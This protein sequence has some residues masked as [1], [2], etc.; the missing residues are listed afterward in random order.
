MS[1]HARNTFYILLGGAFVL[2]LSLGI[3]HG[4]GL[5]LLPMSS[6]YG[7]GRH[8]FAFAM[9]LQNLLWG[10]VQP[11][12]GAIAD[13]YG[14]YRVV[15]AGGL[16]YALGLLL[17]GLSSTPLMLNL[18]AGLLI[19]LG[20]SATS[21]TVILG[22]VGRAVAPE[23]RS[24]A[25]GVASAAGSFGQFAMLPGTLMLIKN[26]QWSHA[27]FVLAG[28]A[29][30]I[31]PLAF[32]LR[33][34]AQAS[35]SN[36]RLAPALGMSA[37]LAIASRHRDFWLLAIGFFVCG[38]Q[39]VFIGIHLPSY[40]M[41]LKFSATVG[42]IVLALVGLFNVFG[43]YIAGWLGGHYDK[44]KLLMALYFLR[45][46]VIALFISFPVTLFSV[47]AFGI[48]MGLLWLSTV[49][50][51]NGIVASMFGVRYLSMLGGIVFLFHQVGSFLG[52][53]LGGYVYD[54]TGNYNLLWYISIVL[55]LITVLIHVFIHEDKVIDE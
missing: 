22:A 48:A 9:A 46:V 43:T 5:F 8:V 26:L 45:A 10:I 3:R 34:P 27:L 36:N 50:L 7:W 24:M 19:G 13:R 12:T 4:F 41:D 15:M 40:L 25:M 29:V 31:T 23:K 39:V 55:S 6:D 17:M 18:S 1:S 20:L 16:L 42:T 44:P 51:T 38:F 21:F 14:A 47:Y 32:M 35:N 33:Q 53:W 54:L 2:A 28:F 30:L 37:V 11:L 49:P 52:G